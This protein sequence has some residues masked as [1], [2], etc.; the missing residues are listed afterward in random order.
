M[1]Y[2]KD[3]INLYFFFSPFEFLYENKNKLLLTLLKFSSSLFIAHIQGK[4]HTIII[5]ENK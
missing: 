5:Q 4:R 1:D 2:E 3:T